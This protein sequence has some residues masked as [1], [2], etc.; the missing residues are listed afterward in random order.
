MRGVIS[1]IEIQ[2]QQDQFKKSIPSRVFYNHFFALQYHIRSD[3]NRYNLRSV[4][5][6]NR[7]KV[8]NRDFE[9]EH[10]KKLLWNAWSTEHALGLALQVD[11]PEYYRF[12][13][14]WSF[15]QAYYSVYL[16]MTAFHHSQGTDSENHEKTIK[17]FGN[18]VKDDHYPA[19]ISFFCQGLHEQFTFHGVPQFSTFPDGFTGLDRIH[20]LG[21]AQTQI[22]K[23]MAS[24]RK[25]NAESKRERLEAQ[26]DKKFLTKEGTFRKKFFAEHWNL[27]Y[28]TIPHTSLMNALYRLRIKANYHDIE[29]FLNA[30]ID[31]KGFCEALITIVDYMNFV[32]E[33]Y[34]MKVIGRA[35]YAS[36]LTTFPKGINGETAMRRYKDHIL[37][38]GKWPN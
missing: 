27:I 7:L 11:N 23:F 17:V 9:L 6:F 31:F 34:L 38:I 29:S 19:A 12:S 4:D 5:L 13:L 2:D 36:I 22:A 37:P 10:C 15:P 35:N 20:S 1:T 21:M 33:A 26:K 18:S 16:A 3:A 30:E 14:H 24:T 25:R 28:Q 8:L 32:H